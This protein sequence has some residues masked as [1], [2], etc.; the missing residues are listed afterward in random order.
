MPLKIAIL[1]NMNSSG[2]AIMR[3]FRDLGADAYQD[4]NEFRERG[5]DLLHN[6]FASR[7]YRQIGG[8]EFLSGLS[9]MDTLMNIGAEETRRLVD[10]YGAPI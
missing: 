5:I 4:E 10:S 3:Y 9:I 6:N 2:F 8:G 7:P 1:G